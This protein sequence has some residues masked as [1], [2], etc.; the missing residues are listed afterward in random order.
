MWRHEDY[1]LV[2]SSWIGG[3]LTGASRFSSG[4]APSVSS[5][6]SRVAPLDLA[7][8][9]PVNMSASIEASAAK[10]SSIRDVSGSVFRFLVAVMP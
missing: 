2:F 7:L 10:P 9:A 6:E 8:W 5:C 3:S 4:I 1:E